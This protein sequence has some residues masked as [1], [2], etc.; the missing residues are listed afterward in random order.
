MF[1]SSSPFSPELVARQRLLQH[2]SWTS[3]VDHTTTMPLGGHHLSVHDLGHS[4]GLR[5]SSFTNHARRLDERW[6]IH[7]PIWRIGLGV[8]L[9]WTSS[10]HCAF[11]IWICKLECEVGALAIHATYHIQFTAI[12]VKL[13]ALTDFY[14]L[15]G[16]CKRYRRFRLCS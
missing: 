11:V 15:L 7:L 10:Y 3:T 14:D 1:I 13:S 4:D 8:S 2:S 12:D 16:G 6:H 9:T 5:L